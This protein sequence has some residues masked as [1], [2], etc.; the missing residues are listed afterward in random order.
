MEE[1]YWCHQQT[2]VTHSS[3]T[4]KPCALA[5]VHWSCCSRPA[6]SM[7]KYQATGSLNKDERTLISGRGRRRRLCIAGWFRVTISVV[8]IASTLGV[9]VPPRTLLVRT[10]RPLP[11][12][13]RWR[14]APTDV[15]R[16]FWRLPGSRGCQ[17]RC[18]CGNTT[19]PGSRGISG[20][21]GGRLAK[22]C[23]LQVSRWLHNVYETWWL[24]VSGISKRLTMQVY[25]K[26]NVCPSSWPK[27]TRCIS[28][29]V[30]DHGYHAF[31]PSSL[32]LPL[33]HPCPP[34]SQIP[35]PYILCE[36]QIVQW[37]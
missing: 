4:G 2:L 13:R 34:L 36:V 17:T 37:T 29:S 12:T 10:M 3:S 30:A 11:E 27:D 7:N 6:L 18:W 35:L 15:L 14:T 32:S 5:I 21:T 23:C 1:L 16:C 22:T 26:Y 31:L 8:K 28:D 20:A 25:D 33:H 24:G 9:E 19:R